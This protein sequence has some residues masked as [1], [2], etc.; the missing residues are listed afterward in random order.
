ML[1]PFEVGGRE[2]V[3]EGNHISYPIELGACV[4]YS[5]LSSF[6]FSPE[7]R[8]RVGSKGSD[9][10]KETSKTRDWQRSRCGVR[11]VNIALTRTS[12]IARASLPSGLLAHDGLRESNTTTL[13][14]RSW[15]QRKASSRGGSA[16][17]RSNATLVK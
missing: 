11:L 13:N 6:R 14:G 8:S 9:D 15:D 1:E 17:E 10:A 4:R 2:A 7:C 3:G 16:A 5:S 12:S